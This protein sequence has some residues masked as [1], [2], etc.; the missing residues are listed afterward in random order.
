MQSALNT[1]AIPHA[2]WIRIV[3]PA[4]I[5]YI[6]SYMDK[7]NIGFAMAGGMNEE[8]RLSM[9]VAGFAAGMY[10]IGTMVLQVPA[11]HIA[12]HGSAKKFIQYSIIA[13]GGLSFLTGFV[14]NA[15][16]LI[17]MRFLLGVAEGG[18]YPVVLIIVSNWFPRKEL[19]RA[20]AVCL[21]G[22][23]LAAVLTNPLS[24][25]L[26]ARFGWRWLFFGEGLISLATIFVWFPL[27]SDHPA[28]AK[29]IS[30]EEKDYLV[31][32]LAAEKAERVAA[33]AK[34]SG[35]ATWSYKEILAN[36]HLW[37]L[38]AI[39]TCACTGQWGYIFWLPTLVKKLTKASLTNVGLL[40][41][42]PFIAA[43]GG[44]YIFGALSDRKGNRRLCT[45]TCL[46]SFGICFWIAAQFPTYI[47]LS[48]ILLVLTGVFTKAWQGT[49]WAMPDLVLAPGVSGAA[50]G[51]I[52]A[53]GNLGGFIGPALVGLVATKTG[54]MTY[55]VYSLSAVLILGGII[56]M[57][58][59]KVTA[60]Y[61]YKAEAKAAG[62]EK[63]T[64]S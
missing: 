51:G 12:E 52:N 41:A 43:I 39:Y 6:V 4:I 32:T 56:T 57:F 24:G 28:D 40:S 7:M 53:I 55:G 15:W 36:K 64:A 17:A 38:T 44:L 49:F 58:L 13:W 16:Q 10:F 33:A 1:A 42:L 35:R 37:L 19:G 8:L 45:A 14:Q 18:V 9:A 20:N 22:L 47:W 26:I 29:W 21:M 63:A 61:K 30:R 54:T 23:A 48:C 3:S 5:I 34:Q 31:T 27:I 2:R 59:P 50:R 46:S 60:G 25:W 62:R 11:G